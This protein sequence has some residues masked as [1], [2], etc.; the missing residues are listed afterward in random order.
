[1]ED[2][3]AAALAGG[4]ILTGFCGTFLSFRLQREAGYYRQVAVDFDSQAAKDIFVGL[5]H[6]T[7]PLLLLLVATLVSG[8]FGFAWPLL[9]M[10]EVMPGNMPVIAAGETT[11]LILLVGYFAGELSHYKIIN[12][13]LRDKGWPIAAVSL[14][15]AGACALAIVL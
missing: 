5:T 10:A 4:A 14:L 9:A 3:Y 15:V 12:L 1:M 6:F 13:G 2:F 8:F 11:A 7:A